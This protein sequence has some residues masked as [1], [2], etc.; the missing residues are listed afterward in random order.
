MAKRTTKGTTPADM[1][2]GGRLEKEGKYH[3]F[4]KS[5]ADM[6][7]I[8]GDA[9]EGFTIELQ[10]LAGDHADQTDRT[11]KLFI[12]DPSP[13]H[14]DHGAF[15]AKRQ[16]AFLLAANAIGIES[17]NGSDVEFDAEECAGHQVIAK[18][19]NKKKQN[20]TDLDYLDFSGLEIYHVDDPRAAAVVK[21]PDAIGA[22]PQQF[23][24]KADYFAP[25]L[26]NDGKPAA[27]TSAKPEANFDDL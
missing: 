23:R 25:L 9:G 5:V 7:K 11:I 13:S 6:Q 18:L 21:N 20:P 22:I 1:L 15:C 12:A 4:V 14:K 3:L 10:A 24:R 19:A 8:N 26:K 17:L 27:K 16:C 2:E